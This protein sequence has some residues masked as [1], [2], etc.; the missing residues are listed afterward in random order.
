MLLEGKKNRHVKPQRLGA[1]SLTKDRLFYLLLYHTLTPEQIELIEKEGITFIPRIGQITLQD[2]ET[3]SQLR[4][5]WREQSYKRA[6]ERRQKEETEIIP[7]PSWP[8]DS[9]GL[10]NAI[11]RSALFGVVRRGRRRVLDREVIA[12]VGGVVIRFTG[13]RLDQA[14]LDVWEHCIHLTREQGL[15]A[16]LTFSA[17]SFLK[18]IG[19]PTDGRSHRWLRASLKRLHN[20]EV[21]ISV[22][23]PSSPEEGYQGRLL[24]RWEIADKGRHLIRLD[25]KLAVL[26]EGHQWTKLVW[27]Q[28]HRLKG[29][30]LAQW[31][32]GFFS[33]H[34]EPLPYKVE[35]LRKL[36][37]SEMKELRYFRKELREAMA[38]LTK[39]TGWQVWIDERDCL[40][41][42]RSDPSSL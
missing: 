40:Q 18:A 42:I 29:H 25:P 19:R 20:S 24:K 16:Y 30:P 22:R 33:T 4:P 1:M 6:E 3:L 9:R 14:D 37:G 21:E 23:R 13:E 32:H 41:V 12:A 10:P 27:Q 36:C 38:L 7:L 17:H 31:L 2:L 8:E 15:G 39:A 11:L 34:R 26:Y 5:D 28:R 35:T